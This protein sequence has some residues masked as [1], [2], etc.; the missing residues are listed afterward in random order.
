MILRSE[1]L[2]KLAREQ[3]ITDKECI[4]TNKF[5]SYEAVSELAAQIFKS[6]Q[7]SAKVLGAI[8]SD[9]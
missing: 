5:T 2:C 4:A 7:A 6:L 3:V 8:P 1:W 9:P